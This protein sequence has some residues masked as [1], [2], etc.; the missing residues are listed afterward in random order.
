MSTLIAEPTTSPAFAGVLSPFAH[1][2][3]LF[4]AQRAHRWTMAQ[5]N[6]EQRQRR[7]L[8]FKAA[9]NAQREA[10][11][12]AFYADYGKPQVE[13]D[14]LEIMPVLAEIDNAVAGLERWM[15]PRSVAAPLLLIGSRNEIRMEPR[16]VVLV[17]GPYNYPL[18]LLLTP[19]VAA[20]AAGNCVIARPS[21]KVPNVAR[22]MG[23]IIAAA[24]PPEEVALV[25]GE[26]ELA[27][28]LLNLPFD[29]FFFT[30]S[31]AVGRKVMHAAAEHLASVTL[32]LGGKSP[33]FVDQTADLS[34]VVERLV[35]GKTINAGQ[36]CVAP[37]YVLVHESRHDAFIDAARAAITRFYGP[38]PAAQL[39]NPDLTQM[40]DDRAFTRL[41]RS[42]DAAIRAGAVV[43]AGGVTDPAQRK[44]APT[45]LTNVA[46]DNPIMADEIFGPI[47]PVLSYRS[48]DQALALV[49]SK[50]KP[51]ALYIFSQ[52]VATVERILHSTT[53]GGAVVNDTVIHLGNPYLPF[54]GTGPSGTGSYHGEYGF[55][56]FS[57]ER[58]VLRQS[59]LGAMRMLYPPYTT[60]SHLVMKLAHSLLYGVLPALRRVFR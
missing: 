4:A 21:E 34:R 16:G 42:L 54:G 40:I 50:D 1:V 6:V 59:N 20:V 2:E 35:W 53:S 57:H 43:G 38:T 46:A 55:R 27:D 58:A 48:L 52:D 41:S 32:E 8:R 28:A 5:T 25:G 18:L 36:T 13:V 10:L 17:L 49:N 30:G 45:L 44:I 47:L 60:R 56:A 33:A 15:R 9:I 37:D 11:Y 12:Q 26:I 29:H 3:Q 39:R 14:L 23:A 19:I 24:F 51:L 7:L 31:G 22:V